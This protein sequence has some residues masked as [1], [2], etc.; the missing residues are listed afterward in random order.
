MGD[1]S[2]QLA[3]ECLKNSRDIVESLPKTQL[4][5]NPS[6][7]QSV[8]KT[9]LEEGLGCQ[10][11]SKLSSPAKD[12]NHDVE[13]WIIQQRQFSCLKDLI[14]QSIEMI[15]LHSKQCQYT[16]VNTINSYD[17][18]SL[19]Y[20]KEELNCDKLELEDDKTEAIAI[21]YPKNDISKEN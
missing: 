7:L 14:K 10:K 20:A 3:S 12:R 4:S 19:C 5:Q 13:V 2:L 8:F 16:D 21:A 1:I 9:I 6:E 17:D 15:S 11:S 18:P